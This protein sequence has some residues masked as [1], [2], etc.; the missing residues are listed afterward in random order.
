MADGTA[1]DGIKTAG[2]EGIHAANA[3][4]FLVISRSFH[5][6]TVIFYAKGSVHAEND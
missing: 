5:L 4:V 3:A 6:F 2:H 1:R